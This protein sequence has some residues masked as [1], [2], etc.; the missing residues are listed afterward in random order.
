MI[1]MKDG[2]IKQ[3]IKEMIYNNNVMKWLLEMVRM[4]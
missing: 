2:L 4:N 3:L 1:H